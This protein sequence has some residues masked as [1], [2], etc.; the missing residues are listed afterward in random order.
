M[1]TPDLIYKINWRIILLHSIAT[2]F[3]I[4]CTQQFV[5][6]NDIE[7]IKLID[8]YGAE[9]SLKQLQKD[10]NGISRISDF[11]LWNSMS[12][13]IGLLTG[14]ILSLII[15]IRKKMFWLNSLI[16]F[17]IGLLFIKLGLF[18]NH[19]INTL[20]Y[21]FDD[22]FPKLGLLYKYIIKGTILL[23]ITLL[24]FFNKWI[25]NFALNYMSKKK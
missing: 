4:L 17:F 18:K 20:F 25:N 15:I 5:K 3:I 11:L 24:I 19:I 2:I 21:S 1:K 22:I 14:F 23:S 7:I 12:N 16:I 6:L 13:M 10:T 9:N 8:K